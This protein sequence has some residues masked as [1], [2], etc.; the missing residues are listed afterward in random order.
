[1]GKGASP[2]AELVSRIKSAID[3][4]QKAAAQAAAA[5]GGAAAAA[6]PA[7]AGAA[8]AGGQAPPQT[9]EEMQYALAVQMQLQA[10]NSTELYGHHATWHQPE[11]VAAPSGPS[12]SMLK[13]LSSRMG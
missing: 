10:Q 7:A 8:A 11:P 9:L 4:V 1:M 2:T 3:G 5:A 13:A 12:W 6:A